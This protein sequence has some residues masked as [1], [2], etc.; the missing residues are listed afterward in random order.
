MECRCQTLHTLPDS[1][2]TVVLSTDNA[3]LHEHLIEI[4]ESESIPYRADQNAIVYQTQSLL[5]FMKQWCGIDL[6]PTHER[7]SINV[8]IDD[9]GNGISYNQIAT[10]RS[11]EHYCSLADSQLLVDVLENKSLTTYF[12][13]IIQ[14]ADESI[15]GYECLARGVDKAGQLISPGLL[16]ELAR[17]SD[18]LF[19]LDRYARENALKSAATKNIQEHVFINFIPTAIYNPELCL[20]DT[21]RW[22][23]Q[24]DYDLSKIVFEVVETEKID[25]ME[26]LNIILNYY[27]RQGVKTALDDVGSGYSS[28]QAFAQLHPDIIKLDHSLMQD[29]D[30]T[31]LKASILTAIL[32]VAH[33]NGIKVL[34]EGVETKEEYDCVKK[35]GVDYVQGYFIAKPHPEPIREIVIP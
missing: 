10:I 8:F 18:Q 14:V 34:A 22:A 25:S 16:F 27:N 13:P 7:E 26:H 33:D 23:R 21:M 32:T 19:Y 2:A 35:A 17:R 1:P 24:L 4:S 29:I 12:Q 5:N 11:L 3:L 20:R 28:L 15:F 31:P 30:K 9:S 6:L